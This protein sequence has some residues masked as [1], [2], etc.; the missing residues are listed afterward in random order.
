MSE[1]PPCCTAHRVQPSALLQEQSSGGKSTHR[2]WV[3]AM[4]HDRAPLPLFQ[5]WPSDTGDSLNE[6]T[7]TEKRNEE[8]D[9]EQ[10]WPNTTEKTAIF[11][12]PSWQKI[13]IK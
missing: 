8:D 12:V 4:S 5:A 10:R 3:G 7:R 6:V 1:M 2:R 13:I 9:D 11:R